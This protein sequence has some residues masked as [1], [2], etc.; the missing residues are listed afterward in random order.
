MSSHVFIAPVDN[1]SIKRCWAM[2]PTP[3]DN[4]GFILSRSNW[5]SGLAGRGVGESSTSTTSSY[6]PGK[7]LGLKWVGKGATAVIICANVCGGEEF[8]VLL[9]GLEAVGMLERILRGPTL[10]ET[11]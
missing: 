3:I 5:L 8:I 2:P 1:A 7:M 10:V 11:R 4:T 6:G 9:S